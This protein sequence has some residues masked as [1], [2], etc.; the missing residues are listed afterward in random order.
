MKQKTARTVTKQARNGVKPRQ[1]TTSPQASSQ[2]PPWGFRW[3]AGHFRIAL[4]Q[5]VAAIG[6]VVTFGQQEGD[7]KS[8]V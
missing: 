2:K 5:I 1:P 8:V 3:H 4:W 7:R 6:I